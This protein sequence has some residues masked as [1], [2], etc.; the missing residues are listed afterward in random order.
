MRGGKSADFFY[1]RVSRSPLPA[2]EVLG[3]LDKE[4]SRVGR[5]GN[6]LG[7]GR[8]GCGGGIDERP[9]EE[10]YFAS[11]SPPIFGQTEVSRELDWLARRPSR[12]PTRLGRSAPPVGG[13]GPCIVKVDW[14]SNNLVLHFKTYPTVTKDSKKIQVLLKYY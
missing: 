7:A 10:G 13:R 9:R 2:L 1:A 14:S 11:L 12:T 6:D 3:D 4:D 8:T 5:R